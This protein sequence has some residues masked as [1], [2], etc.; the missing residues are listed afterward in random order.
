MVMQTL[1]VKQ[2][3]LRSHGHYR[4]ESLTTLI[5]PSNGKLSACE[6]QTSVW[7]HGS[8]LLPCI[9]HSQVFSQIFLPQDVPC[10]LCLEG[11]QYL[12]RTR[13]ALYMGALQA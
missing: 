13:V 2:R 5:L 1:K 12:R 4:S 7:L 3:V 10:V 8:A 6:N 11:A 9:A